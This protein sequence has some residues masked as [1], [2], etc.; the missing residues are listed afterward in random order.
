MGFATAQPVPTLA[1]APVRVHEIVQQAEKLQVHG[2]IVV[3]AQDVRLLDEAPAGE[4]LQLALGG[5]NQQL[6]DVAR[7]SMWHW[8]P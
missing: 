7:D 6:G 8:N 3:R 5:G 2:V 1:D 4:V